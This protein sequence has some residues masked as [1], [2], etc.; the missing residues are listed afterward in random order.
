M[1]EDEKP[2]DLAGNVCRSKEDAAMRYVELH[3]RI[4]EAPW[5][6]CYRV[7]PGVRDC[8]EGAP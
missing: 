1:D 4:E 3:E 8:A 2:H 5:D 7:A 6:A